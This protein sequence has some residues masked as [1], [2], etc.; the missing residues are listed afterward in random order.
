MADFWQLFI[1]KKAELLDLFIQ[2]MNMTMLAVFIALAIGVPVG[3][4]IRQNK[5]VSNI[6]ISIANVLQSIPSIALLALAIPIVGIGEKPAIL[7]VI[8]Y[9][10]LP[11]IKNTF[12]GIS[13][14]DPQ[15]MEVA[16][17][18]GMSRWKRLLKV[19]LPI[20]A[21]S[22]MSGI[23]ISAVAAVG[24]MTIAAFA[25]AE[26]L[27]WFI[28]LGLN[29]RNVGLVL[30][31][32]IPAS[33]L[34]LALDFLLARLEHAVT[35]EG[36]LPASKIKNIPKK[37]KRRERAIVLTI[38]AVL[39]LTPLLSTAVSSITNAN[40][41]KVV[42]GSNNF[43][44]AII[45]GYMYADLIESNTDITVEKRL[46]LNGASV[47]FNALETGELDM[48]TSY[49]GTALVS[50]LHQDLTTTDPD[51]V[52]K[53]VSDR[54]MSEHNIYTSAPLGF[55]N[56]YVMCVT[57]EIAERYNLSKLSDLI[58]VADELRL[59]CTVEFIQREDCLPK[60]QE[61]YGVEFKS[62]SGLD[63]SIRYSAVE[64]G[65]VDVIDGYATDALLVKTGL[66]KLEDDLNF[67]PPYY[68]VNFTQQ[69]TIDKYPELKEVIAKLDGLIDEDT[70]AKLNKQVDIDGKDASVVAHEFLEEKGLV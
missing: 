37:K 20:A 57:P 69:S 29:S 7:M 28:N 66:I 6:V 30:L 12:L 62:V 52:Y 14:I 23:R 16:K 65:E 2:H 38:C 19:E 47:Y 40:E 5:V 48:V 35:P 70:M 15:I 1:D 68:S 21:P 36:L 49:T 11:I 45:L 4:L 22:I 58:K 39:V 44:E 53:K 59:G 67:F 27:G 54:M 55:N 17:G 34:A 18:M 10:L 32:A 42:I 8:V 51:E 63:A 3:I 64:A 61:E 43:T 41:K 24:T 9:A 60:L 56:T 50:M 26:G 33:L 13:S 46:N 31:G 25:G